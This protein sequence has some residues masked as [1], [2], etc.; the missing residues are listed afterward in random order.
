MTDG[1]AGDINGDGIN[2]VLDIVGLV[3]N[4]ITDSPFEPLP[5]WDYIDINTNSEYFGQLIG[6][7][8]FSDRVSLYYFGKAG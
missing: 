1:I 4:I 3:N 6:P 5:T 7:D 2:N 8:T